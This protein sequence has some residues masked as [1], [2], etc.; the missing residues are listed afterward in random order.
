MCAVQYKT[1]RAERSRGRILE[2][3]EAHFA[4]EGYAATRLEDIA[5][6]VGMRRAALFYHFRDKR[7]LYLAVLERIFGGL[8]EKIQ[9]V[10]HT[11]APLPQRIE[12]AISAWVSYVGEHPSLPK[13]LLRE[14]SKV[15]PE[16]R[17]DVD[18]L[19]A[20][21]LA[22]I[23]E[24]FAEGVRE[25][26]FHQPPIGPL[27]FVSA[28]VGAT[29]FFVGAIP[30]FVPDLDFDPISPEHLEAHRR[31]MLTIA[32]RLLGI[33]GPKLVKAWQE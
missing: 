17:E 8:L 7:E 14:G 15:P 9:A 32:R 27:H 24:V 20:P 11:S 3:A 26:H 4:E 1:V 33:R 13:I 6:S 28:I 29:V 10:L 30:S 5:E 22:V 23:R 25:G 19:A 21:F 2:A 12:A 18:R 31:E 16:R